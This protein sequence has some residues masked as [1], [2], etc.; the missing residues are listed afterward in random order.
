MAFPEFQDFRQR[1]M[2]SCDIH[3]NSCSTNNI[4]Q[5][6]GILIWKKIMISRFLGIWIHVIRML[7]IF[8]ATSQYPMIFPFEAAQGR[9]SLVQ[10][11]CNAGQTIFQLRQRFMIRSMTKTTLVGGFRHFFLLIQFGMTANLIHIFRPNKPPTSFDSKQRNIGHRLPPCLAA[12]L[13]IL[14]G[15]HWLWWWPIS[16][17]NRPQINWWW[18]S[19]WAHRSLQRLSRFVMSN[20]MHMKNIL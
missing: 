15:C 11:V 2:K 18:L 7:V 5:K 14:I 3:R 6:P 13:N 9:R 4:I 12:W 1:M 19:S 17:Q 10:L 20:S 16:L 8:R